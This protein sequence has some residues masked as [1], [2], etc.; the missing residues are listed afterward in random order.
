MRHGAHP[1]DAVLNPLRSE[2][3][4]ELWERYKRRVNLAR[5]GL[6][7]RRDLQMQLLDGTAEFTVAI[8]ISGA[9][10]RCQ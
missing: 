4:R 8:P 9:S 7:M 3:T 1:S 10:A 6:E 2:G 5:N